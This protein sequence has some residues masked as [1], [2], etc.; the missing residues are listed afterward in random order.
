MSSLDLNLLKALDILLTEGSV[1]SAAR[2]MHLS[3]SAMSRTLS[4]I[5]EQF[6][7]PIMVRA[8]RSLVPTL[9]ALEL[10]QQVR[11]LLDGAEALLK[12]HPVN[13]ASLER[14]FTI[15]ANE[16]FVV[17]FGG[18][19]FARLTQDAPGVRLSFVIKSEKD[20]KALREGL[21]DL[22]IGV[23]GESGPEIRLQALLRDRFIGVVATDHPL[24]S[25]G[26]ITAKRYTQYSHVSVSR[27]ALAS[28]PID[29]ALAKQHLARKVGVVAPS[30]PA[31]LAIA[32]RTRLV[33]NVPERQTAHSRKGMHSFDLPISTEPV[34]VSMMWHPRSDKDPSHGWL[35]ACVL[36]ICSQDTALG[37]L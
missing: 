15:R 14:N 23:L 7:D 36:K 1:G 33:A 20:A 21:I 8:G 27:R 5:R 12:S 34:T 31:A 29:E 11:T 6:G 25:V 10:Q 18:A 19:L 3:D 32:R 4:R 22:D 28:G 35:R 30:F 13:F 26:R 24:A 37:V 9:R 2:R 17:E 16:G